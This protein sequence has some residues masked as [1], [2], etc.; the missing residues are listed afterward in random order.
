MTQSRNPPVW[1]AQ[2]RKGVAEFAVLMV[3]ESGEIHGYGIY[4]HL[5]HRDLLNLSEGTLYPLL[6]RL[7]RQGMLHTRKAASPGAPPRHLYTLT[8][9]GHDRLNAMRAHW[10]RLSRSV[11]ALDTSET[12]P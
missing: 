5:S 1:M 9:E 11:H 12:L 2:M 3:I 7:K 4:E 8:Q 10:V 6:A